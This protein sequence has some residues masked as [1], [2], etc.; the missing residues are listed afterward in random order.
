M[1]KEYFS[2]NKRQRNG[3]IV[4]GSLIVLAMSW[5]I[6]SNL[7]PPSEGNTDFTSFT[8]KLPVGSK[9]LG[10]EQKN[11]DST[12]AIDYNEKKDGYTG[13]RININTCTVKEFSHYPNVGYYL[14]LAIVNYRELHGPYK[15]TE[16]LLKN[17][18][19]DDSTLNK[20]EP[21]IIISN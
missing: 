19:I 9:K 17:K 10:I 14:A 16:D 13:R 20:I 18:A 15:N 12:Q 2:F 3:I 8:T 7:I 21:Y 11:T 4:L 1:W 5:L 6:I